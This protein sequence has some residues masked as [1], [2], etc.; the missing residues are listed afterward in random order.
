M[1]YK[2]YNNSQTSSDKAIEKF[3]EMIISRLE[4]GKANDWKKRMDWR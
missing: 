3:S 2:N 4:E 1:A